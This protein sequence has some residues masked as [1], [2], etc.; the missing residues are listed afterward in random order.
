VDILYPVDNPSEQAELVTG[1]VANVH[2]ATFENPDTTLDQDANTRLNLPRFWDTTPQKLESTLG[3]ER[4]II[5]KTAN[6]TFVLADHKGVRFYLQLGTKDASLNQ[7]FDQIL[8]TF[9]YSN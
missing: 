4:S 2:L 5:I 8:S 3:G 7:V 1:V 6:V 9:K